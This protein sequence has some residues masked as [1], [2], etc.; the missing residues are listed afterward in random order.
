MTA[1]FVQW[2]HSPDR[3]QEELITVERITE[4]ALPLWRTRH[5]VRVADFH[6]ANAGEKERRHQRAHNPAYLPTLLDAALEQT[7]EVLGEIEEFSFQSGYDADRTVRALSP[8]RWLPRLTSLSIS[9]AE[10]ADPE[11]ISELTGLRRL[12]LSDT[13]LDDT[14]AVGACRELR[15]LSLSLSRPWPD[16]GA[17]AALVQLET[18]TFSGNIL[19]L[20]DVPALPRVRT[21]SFSG[22]GLAPRDLRGLPEMPLLEV[23]TAGP[24]FGLAGLERHPRLRTLKLN[25]PMENLQPLAAL[26]ALTYLE[27]TGD[28][29][30]SVAPLAT[31]P[32]LRWAVFATARP[33]D[34]SP[35][36]EAP[37]L[38]Q[39]EVRG[40]DIHE[41]EL[42]ALHAALDPWDS[43]WALAEPRPLPREYRFLYHAGNNFSP[44]WPLEDPPE[45]S[46]HGDAMMEIA[47]QR[48]F[49]RAVQAAAAAFLGEPDFNASGRHRGDY[50]SREGRVRLSRWDYLEKLPGLLEVLRGVLARTR[51]RHAIHVGATISVAE[52]RGM[53]EQRRWQ[54][55]EE[56]EEERRAKWDEEKRLKRE[57]LDREHRF[58]LLKAEGAEIDPEDFAAPP[59]EEDRVLVPAGAEGVKPTEPW[60]RVECNPEEEDFDPDAWQFDEELDDWSFAV[61]FSLTLTEEACIVQD[62][63][64]AAA[65]HYLGR[66]PE[67]LLDVASRK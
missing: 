31:L 20:A 55:D 21:A 24:V 66:R 50:P 49:Q 19:A 17:L 12:H 43:E 40:C 59:L 18:F 25:G 33:R 8:L 56:T 58:E 44:W 53:E 48:W 9:R 29:F 37:R 35:L 3:T 65:R 27:L 39:V 38:H 14:K 54:D 7:A 36:A 57:Q 62:F 11:V 32:E 51:F 61:H 15:E 4:A 67:R 22:S 34:Y 45:A 5:G 52:A 41:L 46:W 6:A 30:R 23:L 63:D 47:E 26:R 16:L 10:L 28:H 1:D 60:Q 13:L 42:G 2:V 64:A